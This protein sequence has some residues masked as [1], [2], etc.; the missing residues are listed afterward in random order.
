M[1]ENKPPT[2]Y[3]LVFLIPFIIWNAI[4]YGAIKIVTKKTLMKKITK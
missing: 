1:K 3:F 2:N 4:V